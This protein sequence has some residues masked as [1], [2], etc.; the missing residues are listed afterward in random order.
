MILA[1]YISIQSWTVKNMSSFSD[2][3]FEESSANSVNRKETDM[4]FVVNKA[5]EGKYLIIQE[6]S[7]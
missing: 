2:A 1:L 3:D 5:I 4:Y 7:V 6:G